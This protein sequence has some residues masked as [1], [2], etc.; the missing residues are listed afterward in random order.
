LHD[1]DNREY[2]V[3]NEPPGSGKSTLFTHDI[4][5]W[6]IARDRSIRLMIGSETG[7]QSRMYLGRLKRTLERETPLRADVDALAAGISFD[8]QATMQE[9]FGPFK[10]EGRSDVWASSQFT[11]RQMSG[12]SVDDKEPTVS[13]WGRDEKFLGGRYD[14][15]IWDDVVSRQPSA[16]MW[17]QILEWWLTEAETRLEPKGLLILQGQRMWADDLYR[18]CL[19]MRTVDDTPKYRHIVFQ[20]HD[21][22]RCTQAHDNLKPWPDSCLLDP[23]RLPFKFLENIRR[24]SQR[25]YDVQYQQNDGAGTE[26][27]VDPLWLS[28]G[29]SPDGNTLYPGCYDQ[30]R[31]MGDIDA[32]DTQGWSVVSID[33]SPTNYWAVQWWIVRPEDR[34]YVLVDKYRRRMGAPEFLSLDLDTGAWSGLLHDLFKT[35]VDK[36]AP[37][38]HVIVEINAAQRYLLTQPHV[39]KWSSAHA[40]TFLPHQTH[41]NKNDPKFGVTSIADFFRQGVIRLPYGDPTT[42]LDIATYTHEL[43]RWPQARTDDEVMATWFLV[44]AVDGNYTPRHFTPP[45]FPRPGWV[46]P[47]PERGIRPRRPVDTPAAR[48]SARTAG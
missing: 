34:R 19:D 9:D 16:D 22:E 40:V 35:S 33:P 20:A 45:S 14:V 18:F 6:L 5:A 11:V 7:R 10:P 4:P 2:V 46:K 36:G 44:K 21:D 23:W 27:L 42:R 13:A 32:D 43:T 31:R 3:L 41:S 48:L 37:I 38:S 25:V 26:S 1:T 47:Y 30:D 29:A 17:E 28:G 39:Q 8:G 12:V 15:V 24:T